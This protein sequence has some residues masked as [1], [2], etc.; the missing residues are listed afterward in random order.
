MIV[1]EIDRSSDAMNPRRVYRPDVNNCNPV[2]AVLHYTG[3]LGTAYRAA[4][5]KLC[6]GTLIRFCT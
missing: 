6:S 3:V 4:G 1:A 5:T 2:C